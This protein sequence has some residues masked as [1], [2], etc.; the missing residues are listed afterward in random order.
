MNPTKEKL[1]T[2]LMSGKLIMAG[3]EYRTTLPLI[4]C[5]D[6]TT[7]SVQVGSGLYC[8]PRDNH[9]SWY[10]VE[11]G[12]PS[13]EL[14]ALMEWAE[15]P[16]NPTKTVYGYVPLTACVAAIDECGGF[17]GVVDP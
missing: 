11:V 13:R 12:Y 3:M 9:G 7:L 16:D 4:L 15:E 6:G 14:A 1:Q 2:H 10:Q 17:V 8:C 5:G